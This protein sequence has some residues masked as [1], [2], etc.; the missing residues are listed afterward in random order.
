MNVGMYA[1]QDHTQSDTKIVVE[2]VAKKK[3]KN[4]RLV[5]IQNSRKLDI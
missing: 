2:L 5:D 4:E 3:V 1:E